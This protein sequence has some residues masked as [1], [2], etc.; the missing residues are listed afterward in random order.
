MTLSKLVGRMSIH[1]ERLPFELD[2]ATALLVGVRYTPSITLL[3]LWSTVSGAF[4]Q[5]AH[6]APH[7]YNHFYRID[8]NVVCLRFAGSAL[9]AGV[10]PA[11]AHLAIAPHPTPALTVNLWDSATTGA[12]LP[13]LPATMQQPLL[14]R[15]TTIILTQ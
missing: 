13:P 7:T 15:S 9:I 6:V 14:A 10:I 2:Q 12:T 5:A 1:T 11:L 3:D 8:G 4:Q